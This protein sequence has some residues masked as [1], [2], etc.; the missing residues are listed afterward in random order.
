MF[1]QYWTVHHAAYR[2][3]DSEPT[4]LRETMLFSRDGTGSGFYLLLLPFIAALLGGSVVA[5]ERHSG[6]MKGLMARE[7]R[8]KILCTSM[9][10]GF[11]LGGIGGIA[12]L[13]LNLLVAAA[14]NPH[15]SFIN[16]VAFDSSG[17]V[18]PRYV[19]IDSLSW[20]YPLYQSS[21]Q[22][23]IMVIVLMLFALSGLFSMVAVGA[24][25]FTTRRYVEL[26]IPF[27]LNLLWWMLPTLTYGLV[28]DEWSEI[29]FL[30]FSASEY[31]SKAFTG[32][33]LTF[34]GLAAVSGSLA[35]TG[36]VKDA[37]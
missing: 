26:L 14:A 32:M 21:Q 9:I 13:M 27:V 22:L 19:L 16:G 4:F 17:Q 36:R 7:G 8:N 30:F 34:L 1:V 11:L 25:L 10:S 33:G 35:L 23:L 29:N 15:L 31:A 2:L 3:F 6:R 5:S 18:L 12:P 28:P 37:L 24:S 20:A